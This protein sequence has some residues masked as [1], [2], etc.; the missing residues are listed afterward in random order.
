MTQYC[1]F[2]LLFAYGS[3]LLWTLVAAYALMITTLIVAVLS[4]NRNP[5]KALGW[6]MALLLFP[7]GGTILYFVFGRSMRNVKM[8]SRRNRRKLL[9]SD[10]HRPLPK[11]SKE[12]SPDN[13]QR[14]MLGYSVAEAMVYPSNSVR[15]FNDGGEM[16]NTMFSDIS[17]AKKYINLQFYIISN[18]NLGQKLADKRDKLKLADR[19]LTEL[20]DELDALSEKRDNA[21]KNFHEFTEKNQEQVRMRLTDAVFARMVVDV[22]SLLD[23]MPSEQK[24][25][26]DGEFLTAIA[27]R[28]NE[29]L[30]CAMYLFLGYLDGATQFAQSCGGGGISSDLPWGRNP[31]EDDRRF[32]Y[33]CMMQAHRMMK[34]SQPKRCGIGGRR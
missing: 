3:I 24:A 30:K 31:D 6:V 8:I 16:F 11:L 19:Q 33:R 14:A 12:L 25:R 22:R 2:P 27:E 20:Q 7:I 15:I 13:R 34:P 29:I 28:P 26:V 18:D 5:L 21:E 17:S 23:T 9:N 32:A 1:H 4:E 10:S